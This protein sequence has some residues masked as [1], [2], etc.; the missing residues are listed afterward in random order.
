MILCDFFFGSL[1]LAIRLLKM[2]YSFILA[3][4]ANCPSDLFS[5]LLHKKLKKKG[6]FTTLI[7]LRK[8]L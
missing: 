3:I 8:E 5:N 2:Q 6:Q 1:Q 7:S 4:K